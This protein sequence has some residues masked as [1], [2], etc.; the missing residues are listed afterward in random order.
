MFQRQN[1]II[2]QMKKIFTIKFKFKLKL[3]VL[4]M[5]LKYYTHIIGTYNSKEM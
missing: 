1:I 3:L 2:T 5:D 4:K